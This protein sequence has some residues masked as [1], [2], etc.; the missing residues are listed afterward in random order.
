MPLLCSL[1][2]L[3]LAKMKYLNIKA[4]G[5]CVLPHKYGR[6]GSCIVVIPTVKQWSSPYVSTTTLSLAK[7]YRLSSILRDHLMI[8]RSSCS[9]LGSSCGVS[10]IVEVT[11]MLN[12]FTGTNFINTSNFCS[13][14]FP[15][16]VKRQDKWTL[17]QSL[18]Q[19]GD[20]PVILTLVAGTSC[21]CA[22]S[23]SESNSA[24]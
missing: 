24:K 20:I 23:D 21:I 3:P 6:T 11:S 13:L 1:R 2:V 12:M 16:V 5:V 7:L 9:I 22:T 10:I 14:C 19:A 17:V 4:T 15:F 8:V 18:A